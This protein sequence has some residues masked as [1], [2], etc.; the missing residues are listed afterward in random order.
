M[1]K[2]IGIL[3]LVYLFSLYPVGIRD[4][5]TTV[6]VNV[7]IRANEV[8]NVVVV[9]VEA[10]RAKLEIFYWH[11]R[12]PVGIRH[13]SVCIITHYF[14][15]ICHIFGITWTNRIRRAPPVG[16]RDI[17]HAVVTAAENAI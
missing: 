11:E 6:V 8:R 9:V 5:P 13:T 7:A 15:S 2:Y 17:H 10:R 12:Y 14:S 1:L 4:I 16:T 3:E